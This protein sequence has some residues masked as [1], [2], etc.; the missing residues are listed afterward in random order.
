MG[1]AGHHRHGAATADAEAAFLTPAGYAVLAKYRWRTP[2]EVLTALQ[3]MYGQFDGDACAG[4]ENTVAPRYI[5]AELDALSGGC[6]AHNYHEAFD[7]Y[8][9]YHFGPLDA[10]GTSARHWFINSPWDAR[11]IRKAARE[12]FPDTELEPFPGTEAFALE[13]LRQHEEYGLTVTC[14]MP[15]AADTKWQSAILKEAAQVLVCRRF[16]FLDHLGV[17]Q[18]SPP[19]GTIVAH[20]S[21]IRFDEKVIWG[22]QP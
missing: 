10:W 5:D 16:P 18:P 8:P 11:G 1:N 22:W 19:G 9:G 17:R 7:L 13:A 12:A 2:P 3:R 15:N 20:F 14:L 21:R 6:W 4:Y